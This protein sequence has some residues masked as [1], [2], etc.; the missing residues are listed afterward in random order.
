[1]KITKEQYK[2]ALSSGNTLKGRSVELL[3]MLYNAPNCEA[4]AP[5]LAEM[6]GHSSF[7]PVNALIG[8]LG[9][10]IAKSINLNLPGREDNSPGWWKVVACGEQRPEGFTWR[11]QDKLADALFELGLLQDN[12]AKLYPEVI[13]PTAP[14]IE[15]KKKQVF[16][17]AFERN[18]AARTLCLKHYG[19]QCSVCGFDFQKKIR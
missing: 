5:Q 7:H 2:Q 6:L 18:G 14:L 1:M 16:V 4:T 15:G 19:A 8:N 10:R 11:I 13:S 12:D 3:N 9:K 17:N